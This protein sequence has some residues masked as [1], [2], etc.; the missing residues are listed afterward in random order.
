MDNFC[1]NFAHFLHERREIRGL[2][3]DILTR[4]G[5]HFR[6]ICRS[7]QVFWYRPT[8]WCRA[9]NIKMTMVVD[10]LTWRIFPKNDMTPTYH[11]VFAY[12]RCA[13]DVAGNDVLSDAVWSRTQWTCQRPYGFLHP[14]ILIA[15]SDFEGYK[16]SETVAVAGFYWV[17]RSAY[18]EG[19]DYGYTPQA[20]F[21][22][23][24]KTEPPDY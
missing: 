6:A 7:G 2:T 21:R 4:P 13:M 16:L 20:V 1:G 19:C 3:T 24:G 22:I 11:T 8:W 12:I 5:F 15:T 10:I 18:I 9:K 14:C 23:G 17:C